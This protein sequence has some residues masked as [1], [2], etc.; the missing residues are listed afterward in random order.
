[1]YVYVC[2]QFMHRHASTCMAV[3]SVHMCEHVCA[4]VHVHACMNQYPNK[5]GTRQ[6]QSS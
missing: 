5:A 4:H 2:V 6:L 1:M 3:Y